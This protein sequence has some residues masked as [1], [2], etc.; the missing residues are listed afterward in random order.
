LATYGV[1]PVESLPADGYWAYVFAG[2]GTSKLGFSF[3]THA[4]SV[5]TAIFV[6]DDQVGVFY[7]EGAV[8]MRFDEDE[9]IRVTFGGAA[10]LTVTVFPTAAVEWSLLE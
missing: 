9:R 1:E 10:S 4:G 6:G 5:Q 3:N 2:P 8:A 7:S